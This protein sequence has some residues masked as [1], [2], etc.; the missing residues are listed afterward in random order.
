MNP[1]KTLSCLVRFKHAIDNEYN[2]PEHQKYPYDRKDDPGEQKDYRMIRT[3]PY[4]YKY[5]PEEHKRKT[6]THIDYALA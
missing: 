6:D 2:S 3:S 4:V 1:T 5:G